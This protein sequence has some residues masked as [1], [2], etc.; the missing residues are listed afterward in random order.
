MN[1]S[2][3]SMRSDFKLQLKTAIQS[4]PI[5]YVPHYHYGFV[6][7]VL[8]EILSSKRPFLGLDDESIVEYCPV[9]GLINP[10]THEIIDE[11]QS[12]K[13]ILKDIVN[14]KDWLGET[15]IVLFKNFHKELESPEVQS[16]LQTFVE[17]SEQYEYDPA[18][19]IIIVSPIPVSKLAKE[20]PEMLSYLTVV[21]IKAPS[22]E[23][24]GKCIDDILNT[25]QATLSEKDDMK[26][27][28][29]GLELYDV[30]QILKVAHAQTNGSL[31]KRA[32]KI[33]L[34]EKQKIVR[35]SG[36]LEVVDAKESLGEVGGLEALTEYIEN[37]KVVYANLTLANRYLKKL[38]KGILIVGMPGCGKSM[39]AKSIAK[40]LDVPLLRL[41]ISNLMGKYVGESEGNLRRALSLAES[42]HPCV[43]WIDEIEKAF[44]GTNNSGG[45]HDNLV[46][47]MMGHFLTW[48]Q[49]RESAVYIVA[50]ANDVMR[51]EFMRKGRFDEVFFIDFPNEKEREQIFRQKIKAIEENDSQKLVFDFSDINYT[52]LAEKTEGNTDLSAIAPYHYEAGAKEAAKGWKGGFT[53][54]EIEMVVNTIVEREFVELTKS[55]KNSDDRIARRTITTDDVVKVIDCLRSSAMCNQVIRENYKKDS[56]DEN[57][58]DDRYGYSDQGR[59]YKKM[60]EKIVKQFAKIAP[61]TTSNIENIIHMQARHQFRPASKYY[62]YGKNNSK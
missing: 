28:L 43:L 52:V 18:V 13:G 6:D 46:M 4:C 49:E 26:R 7:E 61:S 32:I 48:M 40:T 41:D 11:G 20:I 35:K 27:T 14:K 17:Y 29:K 42:A 45:E 37:V 55:M 38:P 58:Y 62:S 57:D 12:V 25:K 2:D 8:K 16:L 44:H 15:K 30:M 33:A 51:P 50:T 3:K 24:I 39:V 21:E 5:I 47:R 56:D 19:T 59:M 23:E 54:A 22:E 10:F 34:E 1:R 36:I 9:R 53:G 31:D 60:Q